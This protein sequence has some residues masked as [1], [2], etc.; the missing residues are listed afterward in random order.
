MFKAILKIVNY[1]ELK[2]ALKG[3]GTLTLYFLASLLS[4]YPFYMLNIDINTLPM[5]I[6]VIYSICYEL[7]LLGI[8]VA[9][10]YTELKKNFCDL[11]INHK[12]YFK[13]Y[14]KY[15]FLALFLMLI[16]NLAITV[17][18]SSNISNNEEAVRNTFAVAPIYMFISAVI[19]APLLEELIFRLSMRK[20]FK[21]DY[22]FILFSGLLFG[23]AHVISSVNAPVDLLYI[24]PYSIPGFIFA[25]TYVKS[26]NIFVPIALHFIHNGIMTTLQ[27]IL[28]FLI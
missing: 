14:L 2:S 5:W 7:I 1:K 3:F 26:K 8:I 9:I 27:I 19:I 6:K 16:S 25:Y 21:T 23:L 11:K 4:S 17:F 15:W 22:L 12:E 18:T 13:K 10:Y 24:I 20:I 28:L